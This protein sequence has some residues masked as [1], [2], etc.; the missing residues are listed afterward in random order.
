M[1]ELSS[2]TRTLMFLGFTGGAGI[3][4]WI[5]IVFYLKSKWLPLLE[6]ILD[7][8]VRFYTL[9]V[10]FAGQGV[11]QYGTV[12]LS[13]FHAKRYGMLEKRDKVPRHIQRQFIFAFCWFMVSIMLF[14][15]AIILHRTYV[16]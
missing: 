5:G 16:L 4:I 8:G 14:G 10:F 2:L 13:S 6:D 11:L 15:A 12:F 7:N 1:H 3:F 9:N